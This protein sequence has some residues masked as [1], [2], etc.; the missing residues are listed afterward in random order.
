MPHL[1]ETLCKG[2]GRGAKVNVKK[3]TNYFPSVA[4]RR[5]LQP[6]VL[7]NRVSTQKQRDRESACKEEKLVLMTC[8]KKHDFKENTCA[9]EYKS[10]SR[11]ISEVRI[12]K[13]KQQQF[14]SSGELGKTSEDGKLNSLQANKLLRMYPQPPYKIKLTHYNCKPMKPHN[15]LMFDGAKPENSQQNVKGNL[16]ARTSKVNKNR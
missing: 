4:N 15:Y 8:W 7:G 3:F 13:L 11:C 9:E 14:E 5:I 6:N 16:W 12:K 2:G 1:T 10:F